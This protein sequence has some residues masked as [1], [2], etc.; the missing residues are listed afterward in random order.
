MPCEYVPT[1]GLYGSHINIISEKKTFV[2]CKTNL[3]YYLVRYAT[4]LI[5]LILIHYSQ[6]LDITFTELRNGYCL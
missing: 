5:K 4:N 2:E 3:T 1:N 6:K